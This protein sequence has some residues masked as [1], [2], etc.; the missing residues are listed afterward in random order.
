MA[1]LLLKPAWA[2]DI[3][4]KATDLADTVVGEDR[5]HFDYVLRGS[6][7]QFEGVTLIFEAGSFDQLDL[8][9]APDPAA[10]IGYVGQPTLGA[11]GLLTLS[12]ERPIV[13]EAFSFAVNV[14]NLRSVPPGPQVFQHFDADFVVV[15]EGVTRPI[16]EPA[17]A[18]LLVTGVV[19]LGAVRR[20]LIPRTRSVAVA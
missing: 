17:T 8:A 16:P 15:G 14:V 3:Q 7:G 9:V 2:L 1:L 19:T 4:Y 12:A 10:L 11:D 6:L 5:W 18:L 13:D 20:R